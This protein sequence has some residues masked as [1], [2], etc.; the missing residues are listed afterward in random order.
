M[1][2]ASEI[3]PLGTNTPKAT[4]LRG[5]KL[6][7]SDLMRALRGGGETLNNSKKNTGKTEPY[8]QP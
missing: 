7:N 5:R 1:D 8:T 6:P 3:G 2:Q 4:T